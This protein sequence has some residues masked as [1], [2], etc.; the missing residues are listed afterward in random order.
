MNRE[1]YLKPR[2]VSLESLPMLGHLPLSEHRSP[3]ATSVI[4]RIGSVS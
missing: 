2:H 3:A 1:R 4:P